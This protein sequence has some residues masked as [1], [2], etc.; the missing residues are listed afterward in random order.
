MKS[1]EDCIHCGLC[2]K[3]CSFLEK[4]KLDIGQIEEREDLIYHC[5][6]CGK[7]TEVC[8]QNIDGR[9]IIL[10]MRQK[11]V[12]ENQGKVKEKGYAMLIKEKKDYL[13]RNYQNA[14]VKSV[15]FTGCNFPSF[16]PATTKYLIEKLQKEK[17]IGVVFDCCGKPIAE[18][19]LKEQEERIIAEIEQKLCREGVEEVIMLCPNCYFFLKSRLKVKVVSIY[20]KLKEFGWGEKIEG[21]INVFPPCPDREKQTLLEEIKVFLTEPPNVIQDAQCCGLGG[22]AGKNEP[23]LVDNMVENI[24][25][26]G[27][28]YT[29]CASC[30]GNFAR[31]GYTDTDNLLVKILSREEKPDTA[32]S[33]V[34]R[35]KMKYWREES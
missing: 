22:C 25:K 16:Y 26:S 5:F 33:I 8:P 3:H 28:V 27:K 21:K 6:L 14:T 34:N 19:G 13:F 30:S 35:K 15:L 10:R 4:Y 12:K 1:K 7:C 2:R 9:E 31:K 32:K 17:G 20:E 11:Q 18:L 23:D 29:Y 24:R